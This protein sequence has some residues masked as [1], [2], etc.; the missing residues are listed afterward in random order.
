MAQITSENYVKNKKFYIIF[1]M[2]FYVT[3]Y[4]INIEFFDELGE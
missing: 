3:Y 1:Y 2:T 4:I